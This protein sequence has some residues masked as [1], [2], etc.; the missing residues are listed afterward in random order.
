MI[1]INRKKYKINLD[2]KL[3]TR[4]MMK[5]IQ[6]TPDD[7]E[8]EDYIDD[9]LK[10]ILIPKPSNKQL[11]EFR[12]SD[13]EKAFKQFGKDMEKKDIDFKKKLS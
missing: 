5:K 13:V 3:G 7:P 9:I 11:L 12:I 1:E 6:E 2:I 4:K 8:N 10:D